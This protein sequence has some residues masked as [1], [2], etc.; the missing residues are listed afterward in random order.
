[1]KVESPH[2]HQITRIFLRCRE[3]VLYKELRPPQGPFLHYA[4]PYS[5]LHDFQRHEA[6]FFAFTSFQLSAVSIPVP[7]IF[8][9]APW[10]SAYLPVF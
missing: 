1:M 6:I 7:P 10:L 3:S 8:D 4:P 5:P 9:S 2:P